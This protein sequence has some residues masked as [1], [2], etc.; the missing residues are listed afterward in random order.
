MFETFGFENYTAP[1][2]A[3]FFALALGVAFGF[4]AERS[5]FCFRRSL[6]GADRKQALAVWV[7][8]LAVATLG[9]QAAIGR[10]LI[11]FDDHRYMAADL[12]VLAILVGGVFFGAGMVLTRGCVSRL[13]VLSA[14]G[15]LRAATVMLVFAVIA[16]ATLKGT[17]AFIPSTLGQ[18]TVSLGAQNLGDIVPAWGVAFALVAIAV[19]V[20]RSAKARAASVIM[21][22]AI[23]LLVPVAW[24]GTGYVL[25]DDFDPIA[26]ESLSFTSPTTE[27]LFWTVAS[28]SI[29]A[30]FGTGLIGGTLVGALVSSLLFKSFAWQSFESPRQTGRYVLGGTFMAIGAV[31]AGGCSVGAG[32][33]GIPSLSFAAILAVGAMVLGAKIT[34]GFVDANPSLNE[35]DGSST[36][37]FQQ[38]AE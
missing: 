1:Q 15:N 27:A 31:L 3:V 11:S 38:P 36:T 6:I 17:L 9:T 2:I 13:T 10:D 16:H 24:V 18:V 23:G 5:Q 14:A 37:L 21:G 29:P 22:A 35:Y 25:Y 20:V 19:W 7:T 26:M 28:T 34:H 4:L 12:P 32:L 8:G 33:S 30:G